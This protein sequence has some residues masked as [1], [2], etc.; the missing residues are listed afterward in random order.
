M[1]KHAMTAA[2][3]VVL[4]SFAAAPTLAQAT[5]SAAQIAA[6]SLAAPAN[7]RDA[8][9]VLGYGADGKLTTLRRGSNDM[10]CLADD[11]QR[12]GFETAC[13]HNSL[14]P[15]MARGRELTQQGVEGADRTRKRYD[16]IEAGTLKMP[17]KPAT[18]YILSGTG[19][20]AATGTVSGEYRRSVIYIPY[21]T[22]ESTGLSVQGSEVEPWLM[23]PGTPGAHIMITPPRR[24]GGG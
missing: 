2:L 24:T 4:S 13:Y 17:D 23:F 10:I 6:A 9:T 11:P 18:L 19:F 14:E 15:F 8:A 1:K 16:E 22:E 20:D 5:G 7:R 12:E 3:A 21:A